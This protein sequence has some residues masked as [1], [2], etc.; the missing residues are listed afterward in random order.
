MNHRSPC[1]VR[2]RALIFFLLTLLFLYRKGEKLMIV[3]AMLSDEAQIEAY[4][5]HPLSPASLDSSDGNA[6]E[7]RLI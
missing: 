7:V 4:L 5:E 2:G 3:D 6:S 1:E